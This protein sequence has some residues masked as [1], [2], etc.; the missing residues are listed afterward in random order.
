MKILL[1][2]GSNKFHLAP[3]ASQLQQIGVLDGFITSGWPTKNAKLFARMF[4]RLSAVRRFI[5]R[6]EEIHPKLIHASQFS[7]L[8]FQV[9]IQLRRIS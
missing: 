8:L 9:G 6:E 4:L 5:D 2:N 3:L 1:S 7:E